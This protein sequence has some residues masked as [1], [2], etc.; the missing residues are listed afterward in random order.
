VSQPFTTKECLRGYTNEALGA[1]CDRWRLAAQ[2][3]E[4]RIRAIEH[5]LREPLHVQA[6]LQE[7]EGAALRLVHLVWG[8]HPV[9]AGDVLGVRGLYQASHPAKLLGDLAGRGFVLACPQE[10]AGVF[11]L[12]D[13][14]REHGPGE[15]GP[16]LMVPDAV[17][18]QL[19]VAPSPPL[20]IA[21]PVTEAAAEGASSRDRATSVFLETLRAVEVLS[22]RVTAQGE[23][24]KADE[25]RALE[26]VRESSISAE[27]FSLALMEA[28]E[29]GCVEAREGRLCTTERASAWTELGRADRARDLFRAYVASPGLSDVKLFFPELFDAMC[30][31]LPLHSLRRTYHKALAAAI[32]RGQAEGAWHRIADFIQAVYHMDRNVLFLEARWRAIQSQAHDASHAWQE[33]SWQTHETRLFSWMITSLLRDLDMVDISRG[34]EAFRVTPLGRYA[35][36]VGACPDEADLVDG[37]ALVVQP[38]FEVLLY[39]DRCTPELRRKLDTFCERVRG[40]PVSTY[41]LTKEALYRGARS[42]MSAAD[43]MRML[44]RY[45]MKPIP[46]NVHRQ[47]A[48]WERR[49]ESL[50]IRSRCDVA[51]YPTPQA[52]KQAAAAIP[53]ARLV[54]DRFV[55]MTEPPREVS[56][57]VDYRQP[58]R[59]FMRPEKGFQFRVPWEKSHLFLRSMLG[60]IADLE[61][62]ASGGVTV[63]LS[64]RKIGAMDDWSLVAAQLEAVSEE[65]LPARFR[66]IIRAWM[67]DVEP[68]LS[69]SAPLVRFVDPDVC[70]SVLELAAAKQMVEGRLGLYT[71]VLRKGQA[72]SFR[73][74]LKEHG[75]RMVAGEAFADTQPP[76][77][78]VGDWVRRHGHAQE[79]EKTAGGDHREGRHAPTQPDEQLPAYSPRIVREIVEEA[80]ARRHAILIAYQSAW[81]P[82][83]SI[84]KINPV[85]LDLTNRTPTVSGYCHLHG[86]ARSFKLSQI[87][88]IRV[89]EDETF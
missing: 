81:G 44:G 9:F 54:G 77:T 36:G 58:L 2:S 78:W 73:N 32:L 20:S 82:T 69:G 64:Q 63:R 48:T 60:D 56:V 79:M 55:L 11:S 5:I 46:E 61:A 37:R 45:A 76:E 71:L 27:A 33:R 13:V 47:V 26:M 18:E 43:F 28:R 19:A 65:P 29:L 12:E 16:L 22:P 1:I 51:E 15:M 49:L 89:L 8:S 31:R 14:A 68:A 72:T 25:A 75:I 6:S 70:E 52:A 62:D 38:D 10:R 86:G 87:T 74:L 59:R 83:P 39:M 85:S 4:S 35:L 30:D 17:G 50:V 66:L 21:V 40:G 7:M 42:N 67:G 57:R 80:I 53:G 24:H 88:G 84:R 34:G 23:V 3:K 41:K